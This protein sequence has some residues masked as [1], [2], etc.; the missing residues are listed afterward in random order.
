MG[1]DRGRGGRGWEGGGGGGEKEVP[2]HMENTH[3]PTL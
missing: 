1:W 3:G 2:C